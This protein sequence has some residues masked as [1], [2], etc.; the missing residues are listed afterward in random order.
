MSSI[1]KLCTIEGCYNKYLSRGWCYKHYQR[2]YKYGSPYIVNKNGRKKKLKTAPL[3]KDDNHRH[4]QYFKHTSEWM[5]WSD[6]KQRCKNSSHHAY[7]D[8]AGRG[9]TVCD[10]WCEKDGFENFILDMD[11]K[12]DPSLTLDRINNDLGYNPNNCRWTTRSV[13]QGNRRKGR[14]NTSGYIGVFMDKSHPNKWI[15]RIE[16][17]YVATSLGRFVDPEQAAIEYDKAVIFFRGDD[18]ITNIL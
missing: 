15:A 13:Q 7:R 1:P 17:D 16:V 10:R 2:W 9:I 3:V 14:H 18:G 8:Y 4:G 6:M 12:P 5:T 11:W